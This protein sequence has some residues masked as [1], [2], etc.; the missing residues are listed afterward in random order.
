MELYSTPSRFYLAHVRGRL[1]CT[2]HSVKHGTL[3]AGQKFQDPQVKRRT[4]VCDGKCMVPMHEKEIGR[5]E[6]PPSTQSVWASSRGWPE[7][8]LCPHKPSLAPD[9][10]DMGQRNRIS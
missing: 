10:A 6:S 9:G 8:Y 1:G 2:K 5:E 7:R 3:S 4:C